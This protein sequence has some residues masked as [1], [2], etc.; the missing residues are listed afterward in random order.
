MDIILQ[1][2][3]DADWDGVIFWYPLD[4]ESTATV[5]R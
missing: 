3:M 4:Y 5:E 2:T 1:S